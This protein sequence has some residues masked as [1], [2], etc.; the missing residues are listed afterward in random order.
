MVVADNRAYDYDYGHSRREYLDRIPD[1]QP[2]R[3]PARRPRK[4]QKPQLHIFSIVSAFSVC[5]FLLS[6]YA[7]IAELNYNISSLDKEYNKAV[8]E[9]TELNVQL[10]KTIN[11]ETLEKTAIERLHMQYPDVQGQIAYVNVQPVQDSSGSI[12]EEYSN[13]NDVQENKYI[14][15]TKG[16]ISSVMKL[17]D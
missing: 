3:Q 15:Y 4:K 1:E 5:I 16:I 14:A 11:L 2:K 8:K 17:L 7:Y 13:I 12:Y 9:N 6:R 10:M